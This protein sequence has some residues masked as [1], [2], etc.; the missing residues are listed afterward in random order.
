[1]AQVVT[2]SVMVGFSIC[3]MLLFT[4]QTLKSENFLY[5]TKSDHS[6]TSKLLGF[7]LLLNSKGA[8]YVIVYAL[9]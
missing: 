2:L 7:L 8:A 1:M 9:L 5:G 4:Y 6:I 3:V